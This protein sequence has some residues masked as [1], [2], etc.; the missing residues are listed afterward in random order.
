MICSR[1]GWCDSGGDSRDRDAA[2]SVAHVPVSQLRAAGQARAQAFSEQLR[3]EQLAAYSGLVAA[4]NLFRRAH[5][6]W[7]A[8]R[9]EDPQGAESAAA[10][11]ESYRQLGAAQTATAQVQL[12]ARDPRLADAATAAFDAIRALR[13][14]EGQVDLDATTGA[15]REALA[16]FIALAA[17]DVQAPPWETRP[18]PAAPG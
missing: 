7:Y 2:R 1:R 11:A 12:V 9:R 6:E 10:M 3:D 4:L 5:L 8:R 13:R 15:A 16:T 17:G 14:A 18:E